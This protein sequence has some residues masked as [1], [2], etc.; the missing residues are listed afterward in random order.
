[1]GIGYTFKPLSDLLL[2]AGYAKESHAAQKALEYSVCVA[3]RHQWALGA[4][5]EYGCQ[6]QLSCKNCGILD[7][8]VCVCKCRGDSYHGFNGI[9]CEEEYGMCQPGANSDN[10]GHDENK[11]RDDNTCNTWYSSETCT[12]SQMCCLGSTGGSCCPFGNTCDCSW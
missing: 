1:M 8:D 6:C 2:Y 4:T 10:P 3:P 9:T 7:P 11:C 12:A 5:G